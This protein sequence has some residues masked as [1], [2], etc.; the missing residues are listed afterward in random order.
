M[1]EVLSLAIWW[2]RRDLR[3]NDNLALQRALAS[4]RRVLPVF[5]L[6]PFL[7]QRAAKRRTSFLFAG[8]RALDTDLRRRGCRLLVRSGR[9]WAVLERLL[10]E[11]AAE[12]IFAEEDYSP[13]ARRRDAE[14]AWRL[15]LELVEGLTVHHPRMLLKE[16]GTPYRVYTPFSRAWLRLPAPER[17]FFTP[18]EVLPS[19]PPLVSEQIPIPDPLVEFPAGEA[20]ALKRLEDFLCG[21]IYDYHRRRNLLA[22]EGTSKLS[23]YLR[24]GMLSARRAAAEALLAA[25]NAVEEGQRRGCE[26]W[27]AELVWREF[28]HAILYFFPNVYHEAFQPAFRRLAWRDA[29]EDLRAWREGLTGYPIIDAAMRQLAQSGWMPNRARMIVA[30]FL[31]KDLLIDWRQGEDWFMRCLLDGDLAANNGGWQWAAGTGS[32]AAPYFRVFNPIL[33]G[34]KFDPTGAYI[35]RWLPELSQVREA[36]IHQPW[37]MSIGA[38]LA[39]GCRMGKNYPL[40][41]VDHDVARRR[42]LE[43]YQVAK[44]RAV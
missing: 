41:V 36:D 44:K 43:V 34:E 28:Y 23:P 29:P 5:I 8:L 37:R 35:L 27:L 21:P 30:S 18:P 3:L 2:V 6:D 4:G 20:E 24:F 39:A 1:G 42:A 10:A 25:R 22:V 13:Y 40:P 32:D 12:Q 31:S 14:V 9:P 17:P 11:C 7:L 38:Q 26:A 16:D 15:P 33:Q 19:L